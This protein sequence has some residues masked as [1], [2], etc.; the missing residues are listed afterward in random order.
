MADKFDS[1]LKRYL[2]ARGSPSSPSLNKPVSA[3]LHT[4][5]VPFD[6]QPSIGQL[7]TIS[8]R[9]SP[10]RGGSASVP[11]SPEG[12]VSL[13]LQ[14]DS[15]DRSSRRSSETSPD[16][17]QTL[18]LGLPVDLVEKRSVEV[19]VF[20]PP[21]RDPFTYDPQ[22]DTSPLHGAAEIRKAAGLD[23]LSAKSVVAELARFSK[24]MAGQPYHDKHSFKRVMKELGNDASDSIFDQ[25]LVGSLPSLLPP[26]AI[27][28]ADIS[29]KIALLT[30]GSESEKIEAV[31]SLVDR[32]SD[33]YLSIDELG[34]FFNLIFQ[35]VITKSLLAVYSANGLGTN[36]AAFAAQTAGECMQMCDLNKDGQLSLTEFKKWFA[37]PKMSPVY[38][39]FIRSAAAPD[40]LSLD[41][42]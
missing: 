5:A 21:R 30:G 9:L 17:P 35:N 2:D 19:P 11:Q 16:S 27:S 42:I 32:N 24:K 25:L 36:P 22:A 38:S 10:H 29:T 39:P 31:F 34:D 14:R 33:G 40:A 7:R 1:P 3:S 12:A 37:N 4:P 41:D 6:L 15:S 18:F 23:K 26:G 13:L 8:G 28:L 20:E